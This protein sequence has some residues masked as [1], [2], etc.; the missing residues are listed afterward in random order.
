SGVALNVKN[1]SFALL[2]MTDRSVVLNAVKD[3]AC[4]HSERQRRIRFQAFKVKPRSFVA[5]GSS[6]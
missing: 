1:R 3:L 5:C 2:R 4:C 6:G